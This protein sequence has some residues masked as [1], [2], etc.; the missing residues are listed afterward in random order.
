VG[1]ASFTFQ[2]NDGKDDSNVATVTIHVTAGTP[3][4]TALYL[5]LVQ[6]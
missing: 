5:P 3:P 2:A 6:R 1:D 4:L